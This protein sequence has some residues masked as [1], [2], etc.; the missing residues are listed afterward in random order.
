MLFLA[1][2]LT[3]LLLFANLSVLRTQEPPNRAYIVA[4]KRILNT[5]IAE[6]R[7]I[8]ILY[9]IYN[10]GMK[11]AYDINLIDD[12]FNN[13]TLTFVT[14]LTDV[15]W[16]EIPPESNVT[17][18]IILKPPLESGNYLNF[19]SAILTYKHSR[20]DELSIETPTSSPR[21]V[22][23]MGNAEYSRKFEAHYMDWVALA[24]MILPTLVIPFG[25]FHHSQGRYST[26]KAKPH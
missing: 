10:I 22:S 26:N 24:V 4:S 15:T 3:A 17:H 8:T 21:L 5:Q 6:G 2:I 20:E 16:A 13:S 25:M 11:T 14:G 12:S 18:T 7:D 9:G 19:S 23:L 1:S